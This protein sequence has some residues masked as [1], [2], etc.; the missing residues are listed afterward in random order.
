MK[1]W[2][3]AML[4]SLA[5]CGVAWAG[6]ISDK[7]TAE[8]LA[9]I[10]AGG[11]VVHTTLG[12]GSHDGYAAAFGIMRFD[13]EAKFWTVLADYDHFHEFLPRVEKAVVVKK[14][15]AK[16]W[17][18]LTIDGGYKSITYTNIYT[19]DAAARR[20]QWVLDFTF[21]HEPYTKNTG[22]WQLEPL[23]PGVYLVEHQNA[24]GVDFGPLAAIGN[25]VM[26]SML[27]KDLPKVISNVRNRI[28]SGGIWK[29]K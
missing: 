27:K 5:L 19:F 25:R 17:L 28:D 14:E 16:T 3:T 4:A 8:E 23:E 22:Y 12:G 20:T 11:V 7:L 1:C 9:T 29:Q 24:V 13:D 15:G 26:N 6:P 21:A 10:H 18:Q 2:L